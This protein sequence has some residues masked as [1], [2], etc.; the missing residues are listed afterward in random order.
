MEADPDGVRP[1]GVTSVGTVA[2][3]IIGLVVMAAAALRERMAGAVILTRA[4]ESV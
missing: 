3:V 2:A 4:E 1:P